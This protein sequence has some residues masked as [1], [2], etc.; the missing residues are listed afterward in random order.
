MTEVASA[1][2]NTFGPSPKAIESPS[3]QLIT[4]TYGQLQG[5]IEAAIQPLQAEIA[6]LRGKLAS[7]DKVQDILSENQL[8]QL[9]LINELKEGNQEKAATTKK[10]ID[11]IDDLHRLMIEDKTAQISVAKAARLLGISKERMRQLKP[12]IL[13]DDRFEMGWASV[14]GRKG[15]VIRIRKFL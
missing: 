12:L 13:K 5:L 6:Q 14:A 2:I 15:A 3:E 7:L 10:T 11:H 4:L 9:R 8:I 1:S